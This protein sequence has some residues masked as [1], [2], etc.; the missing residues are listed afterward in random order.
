MA[1]D[2][3]SVRAHFPALSQ[4]DDGKPRIHFDNPAG[5][6]VPAMVVDRMSDCL[7]GSNA[8]LGGDF[9]T[10]K[11]ADEVVDDAHAAM[12]DMLNAAS[13]DEIVFGQNMTTLTFHI[14][15]SIGRA[16]SEGDEIVVG[17]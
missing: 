1:F 9:R 15:R 14:S 5:T 17:S 6:Q 13:P 7:L 4:S 11:K 16:F 10:S 12:A 8:N 3:E 2:L